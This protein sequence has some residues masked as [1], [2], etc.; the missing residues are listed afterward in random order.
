MTS[1]MSLFA[2]IGT[3]SAPSSAHRLQVCPQ[4]NVL[5]TLDSTSLLTIIDGMKGLNCYARFRDE[6]GL[7]KLFNFIEAKASFLRPVS[8]PYFQRGPF[9]PI[10]VAG[11]SSFVLDMEILLEP[12]SP[13]LEAGHYFFLRRTYCRQWPV[14]VSVMERQNH[15]PGRPLFFSQ[16]LLK[17]ERHG[18]QEQHF[19]R[20]GLSRNG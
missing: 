5:F 11:E 16:T 3:R 17:G 2:Q 18:H 19:H 7:E 4:I 1:K 10:S 14:L 15:A 12:F 20:R 9:L 6:P 8:L 13:N